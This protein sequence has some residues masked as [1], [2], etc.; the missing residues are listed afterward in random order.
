VENRFSE[1]SSSR[2]HG[3]LRCY[4]IQ[5]ALLLAVCFLPATAFGYTP[6]SPEVRAMI[7]RGLKFLD[8]NTIKEGDMGELALTALCFAKENKKDHP[9]VGWA[10]AKYSDNFLGASTNYQAAVFMMLLAELDSEE[11]KKLLDQTVAIM[12]K[13][14]EVHGGWGYSRGM[15]TPPGAGDISQTQLVVMALWSAKHAG[16][17]IPVDAMAR[18]A[19]FLIRVQDPSG[20]WGYQAVDPDSFNRVNQ[21]EV[22]SSLAVGGLGAVLIAADMLHFGVGSYTPI[23]QAGKK[24]PAALQIAK[25]DATGLAKTREPLT[26]MVEAGR[27]ESTIRE[28]FAWVNAHQDINPA[29]WEWPCYYLYGRERAEAFRDL[30]VGK[31]E[32]NPAWYDNGVK[33]LMQ[34]HDDDGGWGQKMKR[35]E[36]LRGPQ[37]ALALM[38]LMRS[39]EKKIIIIKNYGDGLLTSGIGLPKDLANARPERGKL[40]DKSISAVL[41]V[42]ALLEDPDNPEIEKMLEYDTQLK[43]SDDVSTRASQIDRLRKLVSHEKYEARMKAVQELGKTRDFENVPVLLYAMTDPD[44]RVVL[45]ADAALRFISRK[46]GGVGMPVPPTNEKDARDARESWREWYR[47]IKPDAEF[48]D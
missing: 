22:R 25:D 40:V 28:G 23:A 11:H 21:P 8:K 7:E 18:A 3:A 24:R 31:Q 47:T 2:G 19:N 43:L 27:I 36:Y 10:I 44:F 41:D 20:G 33:F 39:T 13:R 6:K 48:I 15:A 34:Y 42:T 46:F 4:G 16:A 32:V 30:Y 17:Q 29:E 45:E 5:I 38:F 14:Q 37:T 12:L 9:T 26:K 35:V 1:F